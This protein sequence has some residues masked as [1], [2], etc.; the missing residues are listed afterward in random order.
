VLV[1]DE[2]HRRQEIALL[3]RRHTLALCD[4]GMRQ[5]RGCAI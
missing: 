5:Q 3:D 2:L 4:G 1:S